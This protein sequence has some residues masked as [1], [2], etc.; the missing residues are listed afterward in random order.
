MSNVG[1]KIKTAGN[2][3]V[4]SNNNIQPRRQPSSQK[5]NSKSSKNINMQRKNQVL[6]Q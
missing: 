1:G 2:N 6:H 5:S 4:K 3:I